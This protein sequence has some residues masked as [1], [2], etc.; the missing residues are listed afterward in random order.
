[1][2][3]TAWALFPLFPAKVEQNKHLVLR[4]R[5][6]LYYM[7]TFLEGWR[8]QVC[9]AFAGF[10]LVKQYGT[11]IQTMLV[12]WLVVH[13]SGWVM[14]PLIGKLIDRIG[15]R[16]ALVIYYTVLTVVFCGYGF[17]ESQLFLQGLFVMDNMLFAFTMAQ[18]TYVNRI[19][20]R[21]EHTATLSMGVAMNHVASVVMPLT[22]GLLWNYFGY[23]WAF[24][25][26]VVAAALSIAVS[27]QLPAHRATPA[28]GEEASSPADRPEVNS[29][30]D[31]G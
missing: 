1:L 7:L 28:T 30:A 21:A 26:G 20:P 9:I 25:T 31:C 2:A 29:A 13:V 22:G 16:R 4:K 17:I 27:L 19:A 3:L 23:R 5:Y 15:E 8:K 18:T 10:L 12:L 6:W 24:L 11:P 14:A